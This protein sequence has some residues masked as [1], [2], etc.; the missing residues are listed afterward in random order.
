MKKIVLI[1]FVFFLHCFVTQAQIIPERIGQTPGG[2]GYLVN[3][4]EAG[5]KLIVGCGTSIWVYDMSN[6]HHPVIVAKRPL[7]GIVNETSLYGSV[8]FAAATHDGVYAL[9]YNSP[10]LNILAHYNMK[11]MGDTAA[12]DLCRSN[13]TLYI[14]D[15]F[16]VRVLKYTGSNFVKTGSFGGPSSYA[17]S[18]RGQYLAVANQATLLS[19][20]NVSV[21]SVSNL[22]VAVAV[23]S[24]TIIPFVQD[25]QFADL[26]D[27]IIY[28]C[29]GPANLFFTKSYFVA[30][31]F[32]GSSISLAD[33]FAITGGIPGIAQLNIMNMDSRNDTLFLVT[34]AAWDGT[35]PVY[36]YIPV[37]DATGLPSDTMRKIGQVT[38]GLWHFDVALMHGTPYI[39]MSSEWLGV[40]LSD[41]SQLHPMDTIGFLE[42]GGWCTN[43]RISNG[44]LWACQEGYGQVAYNPDSLLYSAGY[45][46]NSVRM[47]I[48]DLGNHYFSSDVAFLNDSLMMLNSSE[49]YNLTPWQSGGQ[50]QPAYDMGKPWMVRMSKVNTAGGL[51]MA[52]T[53]QNLEQKRWITLFDPFDVVGNYHNIDIDSTFSDPG[54]LAVHDD[55][56]YYGKS[57]GD[58][59]YLCAQKAG[60]GGFTFLDTIRLTM[61]IPFPPFD[62]EVHSISVENGVIAVAYGPQIA[63]F[64]WNNNQLEEQAMYYNSKQVA[65]GIVLKN[66]LLYVADKFYGLQI[67]DISSGSSAVMVAVAR[68]TGGWKNLYG[69][70][71]V[72]LAPDGTIF[73]SDFHAGVLMYR[74]Y[75]TTLASVR[76]QGANTEI[77]LFPN[78]VTGNELNVIVSAAEAGSLQIEIR[79]MYGRLCAY[80]NSLRF[81]QGN[82]RFTI[83]MPALS[84]GL[85]LLTAVFNKEKISR[86]FVKL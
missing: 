40:L 81:V 80:Q 36:T 51:L 12:Y 86:T 9:D 83:P 24:S 46:T 50:P 26:S 84:K 3:W 54:G 85:Y 42:T 1:S 53:F 64:R 29:G 56:V 4:D 38:P 39:A 68:G 45:F 35:L 15:N 5:N 19:Q 2:A 23:W 37:I 67:Y 14:A 30:L 74:A 52:A 8:L 7:T 17:V 82:N 10:S 59:R 16:K 71:S 61:Q 28:V 47:H 77:V 60:A 6:P 78:P 79:D 48:F 49:I 69:S 31:N 33:T 34:T 57:F 65:T 73:L 13:D 18:R 27:N 75:D 76:K 72:S 58:I 21:Y 44:L 43:N 25:V 63:W 70:S 41:V 32:T 22:N 20:G 62:H 11:E 55:T 66:N